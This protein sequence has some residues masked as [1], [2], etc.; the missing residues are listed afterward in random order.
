MHSPFPETAAGSDDA[1]AAT[2]SLREEGLLA[3]GTADVGRAR[4][5]SRQKR[6]RWVALLLVPIATLLVVRD[7]VWHHGPFA[8]PHLPSSLGQYAPAGLLILVLGTLML[9]PLLGAGRSPHV[10]YRP[11]EIDTRFADVRGADVVVEEV[12]KT[13]NLFLSH[14]TFATTMGGSARR[15]ILFEGPPGTGKT[16]LARAMAAEAGVPFL[17]VSSSAFQSMFYGQTNRKIRSYFKALRKYARREGGAIGFIEEIDAIG[18]SRGGMGFGHREGI[19]GVVNELLIQ[20][21]S[22]EAPP[23]S[24]KFLGRLVDALNFWLPAGRQLRK[25]VAP[26]ANMLVIGAT[27]RA[28]DLDPA[29]LR[30]GR[31]DRAIYF[32]LPTRAGRRDI[33]DYYLGKK[34]HDAALDDPGQRDTLASITAGYSPVMIEHLL[35]EGLVWALRRG[36]DRLSWADLMRAKMTSEVGLAQGT[37]YTEAERRMIATHEAGHA[38]VAWLVGKGRKLELL[39]IVKRKDALGMLTHSDTE[40]RF[41][42]TKS[43]LLALIQIAFGGMVAE[44]LFFGETSSGVAGDLQAATTAA[45]QM[46]GAMGMG[47]TLI[48]ALAA[49]AP[50]EGNLA[51]RVLANDLGR[52]EVEALLARGKAEATRMLEGNRHVVETLRDALL[53]RDELVGAEILDVIRQAESQP[54]GIGT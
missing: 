8:F 30:P 7:F 45:C 52:A 36:A 29:L 37:V 25:P 9:V 54:V 46:V 27:N 19:A 21:Q 23:A 34:A 3:S 15:A 47:S 13:L 33:I 44:D 14:R 32:D 50:A 53:D 2:A 4:E 18:A 22:F 17:F 6:L 28:A 48:S 42:Q 20:L 1:S 43:E 40:E 49:Q 39:S 31:F 35:D 24:T 51:A 16:Y 12:H 10:L 38:T 5:R 11:G 41:T 26:P